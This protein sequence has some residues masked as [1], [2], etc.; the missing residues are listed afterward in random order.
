MQVIQQP[1]TN[2][3]YIQQQA[4]FQQAYMLQNAAAVQGEKHRPPGALSLAVLET[5]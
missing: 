1:V 2:Q 5:Q 4:Y 3:A